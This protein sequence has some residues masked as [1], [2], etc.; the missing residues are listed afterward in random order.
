MTRVLRSPNLGLIVA[1]C[2]LGLAAG[3]ACSS[4][5]EPEAEIPAEG[6]GS[7]DDAA[8][9]PDRGDE[10]ATGD[11]PGDPAARKDAGSPDDRASDRDDS[12]DSAGEPGGEP[13]NQADRAPARDDGAGD[14]SA[15]RGAR[16][17]AVPEDHGQY[18]QVEGEE[19]ENDCESD[20][21]CHVGGCSSEV[22]S[23]EEGITTMC[24]V[25]DDG[26]AS[27]GAD[28]G[29]LQGSC[30]WYKDGGS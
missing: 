29:C 7:P 25:P 12:A 4:D 22:C 24:V 16:V 21:D 6:A 17:P 13:E 9:D 30:R 8:P 1:L 15:D 18:A 2:A 3:P 27:Q 28:C 10:A 19:F 5:D 26:W 11:E 23:A 14:P 20:A